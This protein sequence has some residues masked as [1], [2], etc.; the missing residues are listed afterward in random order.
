M[1]PG[2]GKGNP[3]KILNLHLHC[4]GYIELRGGSQEL[5][6]GSWEGNVFLDDEAI[7]DDQWGQEE[8]TVVCR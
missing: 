8:A 6:V 7:C 5:G 2:G 3:Y 1:K 4:T